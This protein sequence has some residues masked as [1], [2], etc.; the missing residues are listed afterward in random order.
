MKVEPRIRRPQVKQLADYSTIKSI[1]GAISTLDG[2]FDHQRNA[3]MSLQDQR[4]E[5][6]DENIITVSG[7]IEYADKVEEDLDWTTNQ[8]QDLFDKKKKLIEKNSD[9]YLAYKFKTYSKPAFDN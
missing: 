4:E 5:T 7:I 1:N 3:Y 6:P 2:F 8:L 9:S